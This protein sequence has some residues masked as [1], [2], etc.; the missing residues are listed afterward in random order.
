MIPPPADRSPA[1]WRAFRVNHG[2]AG[3]YPKE[4]N[5]TLATLD[6]QEAE[7]FCIDM[8]DVLLLESLDDKYKTY[9]VCKHAVGIRAENLTYVPARHLTDEIC[10]KALLQDSRYV[11][12]ALH[13]VPQELRTPEFLKEVVE[14]NTLYLFEVPKTELTQEI[15]EIAVSKN[16]SAL[17]YVPHGMQTFEMCREAVRRGGGNIEYVADE[18][19]DNLYLDAVSTSSAAFDMIPDHMRTK[20]RYICGVRRNWE[21]AASRPRD[22]AEDDPVFLEAMSI[23]RKGFAELD[24]EELI[25]VLENLGLDSYFIRK[26]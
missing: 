2:F 17:V 11:P 24:N 3:Y 13:A 15:C 12:E 23:V 9:A 26:F 18:Y 25:G 5:G 14:N 6:E 7:G 16:E 19:V 8:M 21:A 1:G 4:F 10:R 22:L 20:E